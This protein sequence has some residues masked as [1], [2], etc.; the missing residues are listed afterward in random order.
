MIDRL[1]RAAFF[2][3]GTLSGG[4]LILFAALYIY[5]LLG[6]DVDD[7]GVNLFELSFWSIIIWLSIFLI[8]VSVIIGEGI[9]GEFEWTGLFKANKLMK[10]LCRWSILFSL[11][12]FLTL[13]LSVIV[14]KTYYA[15]SAFMSYMKTWGLTL[16]ACI[17]ICF[18]LVTFSY[19]FFGLSA[20]M[21]K[22]VIRH[23]R[24]PS[25]FPFSLW[26]K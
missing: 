13:F 18:S 25:P 21:S 12:N 20:V 1:L 9:K 24:K 2:L 14:L 3:I 6:N 4:V 15:H 26:R 5:L 11:L 10:K 8:M 23:F 17:Y 16:F 22:K 7:S 19:S